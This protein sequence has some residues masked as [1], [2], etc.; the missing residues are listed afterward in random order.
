MACCFC[1]SPNFSLGSAQDK[2]WTPLSENLQRVIKPSYIS[3]STIPFLNG[4][5]VLL[6]CIFCM[7]L[8]P[9]LNLTALTKL[10]EELPFPELAVALVVHSLELST[11]YVLVLRNISSQ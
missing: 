7:T 8:V 11:I 6:I 5:P 10:S 9:I 2:S 1:E 4:V 3:L